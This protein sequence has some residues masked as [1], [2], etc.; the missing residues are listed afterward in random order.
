MKSPKQPIAVSNNRKYAHIK[1]R[2]KTFW[3]T[4]EME[5]AGV[6]KFFERKPT[7]SASSS[8]TNSPELEHSNRAAKDKRRSLQ[9]QISGPDFVERLN[10]LKKGIA[11][12]GEAHS[13]SPSPN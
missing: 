5:K 4:N 1:P 3:T 7:S 13:P 10:A 9:H 8:I 12:V 6:K 11:R 2:V